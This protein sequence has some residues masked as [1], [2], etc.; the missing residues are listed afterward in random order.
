MQIAVLTAMSYT[1]SPAAPVFT[2]AL[3]DA[4]HKIETAAVFSLKTIDSSETL[5]YESTLEPPLTI[6]NYNYD[7]L[8]IAK[9]TKY[10]A[11]Q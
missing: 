8:L 2:H 7:K 5:L 9:S 4:F 1:V 11:I 6:E 3:P 10:N